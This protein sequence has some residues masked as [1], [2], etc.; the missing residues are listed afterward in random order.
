MKKVYEGILLELET[1]QET[2]VLSVSTATPTV[3]D[4][5][6][7]IGGSGIIGVGSIDELK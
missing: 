5:E 6:N 3:G 7:Y 1:F 2:S 4:G